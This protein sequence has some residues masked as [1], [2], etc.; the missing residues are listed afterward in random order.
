MMQITTLAVLYM[1]TEKSEQRRIRFTIMTHTEH[2]S[3][4]QSN[5]PGNRVHKTSKPGVLATTYHR[6]VVR[7]EIR[8]TPEG[9]PPV[10][11]D[12][13]KFR[14]AGK[15]NMTTTGKALLFDR[16][17]CGGVISFST[18]R[19]CNNRIWVRYISVRDDYQASGIGPRFLRTTVTE[20]LDHAQTIR[21]AVNNPFAYVAAYKA[22]FVFTGKQTGIAEL[23]LEHPGTLTIDVYRTGLELFRD[24][25]HLSAVERSFVEEKFTEPLPPVNIRRFP[26]REETTTNVSSHQ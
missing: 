10:D 21:I 14:Y 13:N 19:S 2:G 16:E 15:F 3:N 18:D 9:G 4:Y 25:D 7:I 6:E 11:L 1:E 24:A 17:E 26:I 23:L 8:G 5:Q 12:H 20:L 22:G